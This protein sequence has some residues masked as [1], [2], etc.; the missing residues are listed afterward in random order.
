MEKE[1][2][3]ALALKELRKSKDITLEQIS[4]STNIKIKYLQKIESGDFTFKPDVYIKLF[5]KEYLKSIDIEKSDKILQEFNNL[6]SV[7]SNIDLTFMPTEDEDNTDL[8]ENTF[9]INEYDPKKIATII[10][11]VILIIAVYQFFIHTLN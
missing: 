6:F 10:L 7:S 4:D 5:L 11:I 1:H 8:N 2:S 3:F 9:D